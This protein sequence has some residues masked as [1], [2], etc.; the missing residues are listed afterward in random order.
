MEERDVT[1]FEDDTTYEVDTP[2]EAKKSGNTGLGILIGAGLA[3]A[4]GA[5]VK[6][7]KKGIAKRKAKKA[8]AE[9][10]NNEA[11]ESND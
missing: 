2:T 6:A 1:M 9:D 3:L 5:G 4:I 7:V 8:A 11:C 10:C